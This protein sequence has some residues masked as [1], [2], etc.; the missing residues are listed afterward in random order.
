MIVIVTV[1]IVAI[2]ASL[3]TANITGNV[4]GVKSGTNYKVYTSAE[5][6]AK[7]AN[8]AANLTAT[9]INVLNM[10]RDKC[11]IEPSVW[12]NGSYQSFTCEKI[13]SDRSKICVF[14]FEKGSYSPTPL[15]HQLW[16]IDCKNTVVLNDRSRG[17]ACMCC[18]S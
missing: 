5:M 2:I 13:C 4:V 6:D 12:G 1:I 8:I 3:I 18:T 16:N 15:E 17:L 10:F 11:H 9:N 7:L 14:G